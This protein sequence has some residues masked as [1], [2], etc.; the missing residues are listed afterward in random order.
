MMGVIGDY[1]YYSQHGVIICIKHSCAIAPESI[2]H[3]LNHDL[4]NLTEA[5]RKKKKEAYSTIMEEIRDI[6]LLLS[7]VSKNIS[8]GPL[9]SFFPGL[10]TPLS[11]YC[12]TEKANC[13]FVSCFLHMVD[14][15]I[16]KIHLSK[17]Q[18]YERDSYITLGYIQYLT[19]NK[20][21]IFP[22]NGKQIVQDKFLFIF[23]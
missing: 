5:L 4:R 8:S 22:V 9:I 19:V 12:C 2:D 16:R 17:K 21:F 23:F 18:H 13:G 15:H 3:H 10:V 11:A 14:R 1:E 7:S 20:S 6:L